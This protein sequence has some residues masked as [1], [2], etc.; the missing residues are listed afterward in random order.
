MS[1]EFSNSPTLRDYRALVRSTAG[2]VETIELGF[3]DPITG[4]K[5][6]LTVNS[7]NSIPIFVNDYIGTET[8]A[9]VYTGV[10]RVYAGCLGEGVGLTGFIPARTE[11]LIEISDSI[12]HQDRDSVY[13]RLRLTLGSEKLR[14]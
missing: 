8:L 1:P 6:S 14:D 13:R 3:L 7:F 9:T 2:D 12:H 5:G 4:K 10:T 11:K